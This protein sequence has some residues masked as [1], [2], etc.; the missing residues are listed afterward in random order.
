MASRLR[1]VDMHA[2]ASD[3]SRLVAPPL[4]IRAE[5]FAGD[6]GHPLDGRALA[7]RERRTGFPLADARLRDANK[8]AEVRLTQ[9]VLFSV[10]SDDVHVADYELCCFPCQQLCWFRA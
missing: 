1:V 9:A 3:A 10:G 6:A 2:V 4:D 5:L 7:R 8:E